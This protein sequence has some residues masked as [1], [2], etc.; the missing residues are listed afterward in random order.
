[1]TS[2][3]RVAAL[4]AAQLVQ[5][6]HGKSQV[7]EQL[8]ARPKRITLGLHVREVLAMAVVEAGVA[9]RRYRL[10]GWRRFAVRGQECSPNSTR[11]SR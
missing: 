6:Q 2:L 4:L 5:H 3:S 11:R 9:Y 1:M 8:G 10:K 7:P